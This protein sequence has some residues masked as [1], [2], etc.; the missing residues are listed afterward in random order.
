M[1]YV[2]P[3]NYK[4]SVNLPQVTKEY[5]DSMGIKDESVKK[6]ILSQCYDSLIPVPRNTSSQ[7]EYFLVRKGL[8]CGV[9]T[10]DGGLSSIDV[11][12][13]TIIPPINSNLF[14]VENEKEQWGV[15][16]PQSINPVVGFGVYRYFWGF[17][18][19]LCLIEVD[20]KISNTFSNRGIINSNGEEV[21]CPYAYTDIYDFY[22]KNVRT[23]KVMQQDVVLYLNK[24]DLKNRV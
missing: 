22:G 17:D 13:L 1:K 24:D 7:N 20:T 14:V 5:L 8:Y 4:N 2:G 11:G 19:D 10:K 15:M 23:I 3:F 9:I 16:D 18:D 21:V 12:Y 6:N